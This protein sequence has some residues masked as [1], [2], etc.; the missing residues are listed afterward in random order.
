M[1]FAITMMELKCILPESCR[2]L[3]LIA[4]DAETHHR[5]SSLLR[6]K[7]RCHQSTL[8]NDGDMTRMCGIFLG[9][10]KSANVQKKV[11]FVQKRYPGREGIGHSK[12]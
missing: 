10:K 6:H 5:E 9:V 11:R 2:I 4:T 12:Y 7:I 1:L 3:A 8:N